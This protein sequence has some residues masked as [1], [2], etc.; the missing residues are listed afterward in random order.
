MTAFQTQAHQDANDAWSSLVVVSDK[1]IASFVTRLENSRDSLNPDIASFNFGSLHDPVPLQK[2]IS[3]V[4]TDSKDAITNSKT[5]QTDNSYPGSQSPP[6]LKLSNFDFSINYVISNLNAYNPICTK[7][8]LP[9]LIPSYQPAVDVFVN[10]AFQLENDIDNFYSFAENAVAASENS[11]TT[12]RQ[13]LNGCGKASN[14][15][16]CIDAFVSLKF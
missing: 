11:A 10:A 8:H 1:K 12:L 13:T 3:K 2:L 4:Q 14:T 9:D 16:S 7:P 5:V 15:Q 6:D